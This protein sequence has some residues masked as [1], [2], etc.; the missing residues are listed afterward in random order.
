MGWPQDSGPRKAE[1][2]QCEA[3]WASQGG[4]NEPQ[5]LL[6]AGGR[7]PPPPSCPASCPTRLCSWEPW[8]Q[9]PN[10]SR[11]PSESPTQGVTAATNQSQEPVRHTKKRKPWFQPK[12]NA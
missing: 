7:I 9:A 5:S 4:K 6:P 11:N 8:Q 10:S 1:E 12:E 3:G 2:L